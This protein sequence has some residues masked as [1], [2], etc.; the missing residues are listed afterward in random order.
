VLLL[1]HKRQEKRDEVL[2]DAI[3]DNKV[4]RMGDRFLDFICLAIRRRKV[5]RGVSREASPQQES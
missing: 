4:L 2:R 1:L 3:Q 5:S